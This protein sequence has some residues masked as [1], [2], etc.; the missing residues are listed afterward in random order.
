LQSDV[1]L[2]AWHKLSWRDL[3][4]LAVAWLLF[5]WTYRRIRVRRLPEI[6]DE[7]FLHRYS[8]RFSGPPARVLQ[9]RRRVA[10]DLGIPERRLAPE[11]TFKELRRR[12]G[13]LGDFGTAWDHLVE[14]M[15]DLARS[16][17][18]PRPEWVD[19]V[20]ELVAG[21]VQAPLRAA[22]GEAPGRKSPLYGATE[23][24]TPGS[25]FPVDGASR[26]YLAQG[27]GRHAWRLLSRFQGTLR[28]WHMHTEGM[29]A[30]LLLVEAAAGEAGRAQALAR[31]AALYFRRAWRRAAPFVP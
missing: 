22:S 13:L 25:G 20:G 24:Y 3:V 14:E 5:R 21:L 12:L 1:L 27:K 6:S 10:W 23:S 8:T 18:R 11:Y 16:A 17:G 7:E 30:W 4:V 19:T 2:V 29:A 28:R 31:A 26:T 15:G 9:V